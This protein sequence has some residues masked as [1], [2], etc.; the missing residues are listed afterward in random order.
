MVIVVYLVVVE[1]P[2]VMME[3]HK[4][5]VVLAEPVE[6]EPEPALDLEIQELLI[7]EVVA[8][9]PMMQILQVLVDQEQSLSHIFQTP[10]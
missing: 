3:V 4:N 9:V 5:L 2:E 8:V 1:V 6:V 7:L 10:N